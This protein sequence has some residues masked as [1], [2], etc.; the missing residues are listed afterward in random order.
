MP[1]SIHAGSFFARAT[2][3][4]PDKFTPYFTHK[5]ISNIFKL[6]TFLNSRFI[7]VIKHKKSPLSTYEQGA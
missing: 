3:C 6:L 5:R 2:T 7:N 4:H 1:L